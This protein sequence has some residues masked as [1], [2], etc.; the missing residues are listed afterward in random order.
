MIQARVIPALFLKGQGLVKTIK[1]KNPRYLGDPIN[2]VR[3]F[4]D[5]E[6]DEIVL[7]DI[8]ATP[9]KRGPHF[10]MLKKEPQFLK[11]LRVPRLHLK[12][13]LKLQLP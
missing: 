11:L 5:K 3:I 10:E 9:E 8:T 2:V 12:Q 7:L 4:N 6:V 1:F 13:V